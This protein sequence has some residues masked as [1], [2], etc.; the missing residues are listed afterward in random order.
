[1]ARDHYFGIDAVKEEDGSVRAESKKK[2]V[3]SLVGGLTYASYP[4]SRA[5]QS[6]GKERKEGKGEGRET[7]STRTRSEDEE[8]VVR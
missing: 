1:M 2:R 5:P 6:K 8:V 3:S 4:R 7:K